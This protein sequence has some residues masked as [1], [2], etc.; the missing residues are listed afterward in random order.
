MTRARIALLAPVPASFITASQPD[1]DVVEVREQE[2][3]VDQCRGARIVVSDWSGHVFV[4]AGVID[5]IKGSCELIQVPASG[6]DSVDVEAALAA[7]VP[8][9]NCH[10]LNADDVADWCLWAA[11]DCLRSL[12]QSQATLRAGQWE[13]VGRMRLGRGERRVGIVGLGAVGAATARR[14]RALGHPVSYWSRTRRTDALERDLGVTWRP[15]DELLHHSDILVLALSLTDATRGWLDADRLATLPADAVVINAARGP[16]WDG[17]AVA[18]A[19]SSGHLHAAATDVFDREPP[20]PDDPILTTPGI[21]VTPHIA[22]VSVAG[23]SA[24]LGRILGNIDAVLN[25]GEIEGLVR[26]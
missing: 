17:A 24:L 2:E 8:V 20:D 13:Q 9:A 16:V 25:G 18:E 19:V 5:A 10:G 26:R 14:F 22:A 12:S 15:P 23:V 7:G 4:D 1:V 6:L 3:A 11:L 21:T